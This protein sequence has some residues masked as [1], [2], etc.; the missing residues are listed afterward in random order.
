[1]PFPFGFERRHVHDDAAAR[2]GRL[3]EA[4][5]EHGPRNAEI[6]HRARQREGIRRYHTDVA[7]EVH[8]T[9]FVET[10]R[11]DDCGVDIGEDLEFVGAAHVVAVTRGSVRDDA[12]VFVFAN[13]AGLEG[14]DHAVLRRHA[15]NPAIR[16]DA[17]G[18]YST[19]ILGNLAL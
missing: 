17:H 5:R 6:L 4:D 19:T 14:L 12:A 3:A 13:L 11:I 15:A 2:I 8:K 10:F 1:V 7:F 18:R 9:R 16:L